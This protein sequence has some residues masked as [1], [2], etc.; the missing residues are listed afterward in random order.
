[1]DDDS[2]S[3]LLGA[4]AAAQGFVL[5]DQVIELEGLCPRCQRVSSDRGQQRSEG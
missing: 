1:M 3:A 2:I 5:T 4:R